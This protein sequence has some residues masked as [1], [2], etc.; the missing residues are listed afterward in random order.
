M[1]SERDEE[2]RAA[3]RVQAGQQ[4]HDQWVFVDECSTHLALTSLY[5]RAPKGVR[6]VGNVPRNYGTNT[7]LIAS[8]SLQGMG[9]AFILDGA[10]DACA[11]EVDIEQVLAPS[12]HDGQTVV[13]DN[14]STHQGR[15]VRQAIEARG[16]RLLYLPSYSPDLSPIGQ[17]FS[18]LK[19]CLRRRGARTREAL[20][21]AIAQALEVITAQDARGWFTHC[22]YLAR[23]GEPTFTESQQFEAQAF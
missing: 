23:D 13:M 14:L 10:E 20:Y 9:E 5:A 15:Y 6:A 22:G 16:C 7:T 2:A 8:L 21:Q 1:A 3:W 18:K 17:A 11:F 4:Q 12:L 19:T